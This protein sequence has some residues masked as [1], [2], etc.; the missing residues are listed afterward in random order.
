ME[1]EVAAVL[2]V[3]LTLILV[4]VPDASSQ[5]A[6]KA[7]VEVNC[8]DTGEFHI[9]NLERK[10]AVFAMVGRSWKPISGEW[11]KT[12]EL[13][14]FHSEEAVFLNPGASRQRIM[15]G[16]SRYSVNCP[17]FKFSCKLI[18]AT[19]NACYK[20]DDTFYGR[21]TAYSLR[22]D[23]KNEFRFEQPFLLTYKVKTDEGKTLT[24]APQI[25]SPEFEQISMS[26]VR[27]IGSNRFT[28]RW[29]TTSEVD[30]FT[31]QYQD[32]GNRLYNFYDTHECTDLP[33]CATDKGCKDN[34]ECVDNLCLP[35]SC[36]E[37]Q[38]VEDHQCKD[39]E[40][41][42]SIDCGEEEYCSENQCLPLVCEYD[43]IVSDHICEKLECEEDEYLFNSSCMKLNCG[44]NKVYENHVCVD[45]KDDEITKNNKCEKLNCGFLKRA[46]NHEYISVFRVLFGR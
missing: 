42:T 3:F 25:L 2:V 23:R 18:N 29:N 9:R 36:G 28:L 10:G 7:Q 40:C 39:K 27:R 24:H 8:Y 38:Y 35:I 1:K 5:Y 30:K 46:K 11:K 34:E 13:R 32:C 41:C 21:F 22:Y 19:I 43:E 6:T 37:C 12:K 33:T 44:A 45:C 31:V 20:R 15:V 16:K 17:G 26:R 4:F 14:E